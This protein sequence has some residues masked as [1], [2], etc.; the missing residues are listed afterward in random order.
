TC[1]ALAQGALQ[2]TPRGDASGPNL[3]VDHFLRALAQTQQA[4]AIGVVLSGAGSDG[5]LGLLEI[6]SVGGITF[7][8]EP[9][10]AGHGGMPQS[11]IGSGA[12]DFV[13][14]P[15][16]I[17]RR[18]AEVAAHPYLALGPVEALPAEA[19]DHF[20]RVLGAVRAATKVDF[21]QYRDTTVR[22][23][24]MRRMALHGESSLAA[25]AERLE[26]E[27]P[28]A[29]G[30]YRDLLINVTSF[31]RDPALFEALKTSV[32]PAILEAKPL[33][34]P[35]RLW[36]PGCSTGQEP[37][38]L[39]IALWE[40]FDDQPVSVRRPFQVFATDLSDPGAL[41]RARAG[42]YPE[43]I[44]AEVSPERLHRF[45]KKD[46]RLYRIDKSIRDYCIFARQNLSTDPPFSRVDLISCRNVLIYMAPA[47]QRRVLRTF[48]Y[49]LNVPGFLILGSS[50]TAG[51]INGLF[52]V[53]DRAHKIYLKN[54]TAG[55]PLVPFAA[56]NYTPLGTA[57]MW[58]RLPGSTPVDFQKEADRLLLGRYAPP[59]V[60]I[61]E[62]LDILQF[63]GRTGPYV[64]APAGEPTTNLLK[65]ARPGLFVELRSAVN[66][67]IARGAAVRREG[68][69][70]R[71]EQGVREVAIEV[72]PV[73]P[74]E[75]AESCCL[76]LFEEGGRQAQSAA[77]PKPPSGWRARLSRA[78]HAPA[79][80]AAEARRPPGSEGP[81]ELEGET[82]GLRQELSST[83]EY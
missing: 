56:E 27:G 42:L 73:R 28:E 38:S 26:Q 43:T 24:I 47:L 64:E 66:E 19:E 53:T 20:R 17:A 79:G 77:E 78:L 71:D 6:K 18:L 11:A 8:Q 10:T 48:H 30:L 16:G 1:M 4:Q 5:T 49:A 23:R 82:A 29:E 62:H 34:E 81:T 55:R 72:L 83:R 50:E 74:R 15:E 68:L 37:Y 2:L 32:F 57:G 14:P 25:Y 36:V 9:G 3:P 67:S 21:S 41:E 12:V 63:R 60:L 65:M 44:E 35:L 51:E 54:V 59:G 7:A 13:L 80:P 46:D 61:N 69:H 31:F 39:A 40:F 70:L 52:E 76:V 58:A 45:F 33:D 75:S 22:R